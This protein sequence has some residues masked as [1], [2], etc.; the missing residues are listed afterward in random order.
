MNIES[1]NWNHI[2]EN[3]VFRYVSS[4]LYL[5]VG[6]GFLSTLIGVG[7]AWFVTCHSFYGRKFMEWILILPLT[8]MTKD[9]LSFSLEALSKLALKNSPGT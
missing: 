3:L 1:E 4:T 8:F 7:C 5:V 2:K 9:I 6:V